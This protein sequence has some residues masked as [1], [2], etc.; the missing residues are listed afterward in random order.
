MWAACTAPFSTSYDVM[1][2]GRLDDMDKITRS[3]I[4]GCPVSSDDKEFLEV[5]RNEVVTLDRECKEMGNISPAAEE[6]LNKYARRTDTR[7]KELFGR[8]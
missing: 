2:D 5:V 1:E 3:L 6:Y 4:E 7:A 8:A